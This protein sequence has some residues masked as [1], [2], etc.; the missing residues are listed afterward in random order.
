VTNYWRSLVVAFASVRRFHPTA[1]LVLVTTDRVPTESFAMELAALEVTVL[2]RE[3]RWRPP[4]G[5][6][7]SFGASLYTL[8]AIEALADRARLVL[9]DPDVVCL[10]PMVELEP[11]AALEIRY[12]VDRVVNG[13]S[14]AQ[15][16]CLH[17]AL[18]EPR[19]PPPKHFGGEVYVVSSAYTDALL[20][21]A[22]SAW[23]FGLEQWRAGRP[24]FV[25]EEHLLS[26]ALLGIGPLHELNGMAGRI[27]TARRY[28][29]VPDDLEEM[30]L[31]HLPG[32]KD[33]GLPRLH[34]LARDPESR[35]WSTDAAGF[36]RLV[37][38][39]AGL[40]RR[41]L[42]RWVQDTAVRAA[43]ALLRR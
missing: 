17:A 36:R 35:F 1:E 26:Y 5:F 38:G 11:L 12:D 14:R 24:C 25:T 34:R 21:R 27:W 31:W 28:R 40:P 29:S 6:T 18:G 16:Q 22:R 15:A 30:I 13:L 32:E 7:E 4:E 33:R 39:R 42:P 2:K 19:D 23:A 37:G 3:F 41:S 43:G 10:G 20:E 9:L 8:D